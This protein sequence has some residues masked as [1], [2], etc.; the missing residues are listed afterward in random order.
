MN[1]ELN[2]MET[3]N[4]LGTQPLQTPRLLLRRFTMDDAQAMFDLWCN[5]P[6]V[7]R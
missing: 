3:A 2:K 5:D 6:E 7:T 4:H 1:Y